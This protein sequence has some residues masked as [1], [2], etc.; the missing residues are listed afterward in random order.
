MPEQIV[1]VEDDRELREL[2]IEVLGDAGYAPAGFA[3]AGAALQALE[4]GAPGDLV[5]TDLMM[6]GMPGQELL[7]E[8]RRRAPEVN[9][10]VMTAFGSIDSAIDLVKAGAFDY[11]TK[12]LATD[13]LLLAVERA[14]TESRSR[15]E[16]AQRARASELTIPRG[17]VGES[18]PMKALY[19]LIGRA[20]RSAHP[21]LITGESGTGKELVARSL[22]AASGRGAFVTVNCGA[23]PENLLESELFGHERGAFTGADR[24]KDGLFQVADGGTLFLDEIAELPLPL[25]PKLLRALEQSEI[26]RVGSVAAQTVDVRLLAA[27]NRTLE[28]EVEVGRF[29]DDLFWRLNVLQVHVP[30][31]RERADDIPLLAHHFL[32]R[33]AD[34]GKLPRP[35]LPTDGQD[36]RSAPTTIAPDTMLALT[37][38]P[39]PG[40]VRELRNAI[41]RAGTLALGDRIEL[42]DLPARIHEGGEVAR[43]INSASRRNITLRELERLYILEIV[44]RTEGNKSKAAEL[45]GLDRKTLYRKLDEYRGDDPS[46]AL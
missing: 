39:W 37:S 23:L 1:I 14:L 12:P 45:L 21:V 32:T 20:A 8:V 19:H 26:R 17:F 24:Q 18:A 28:Q 4:R 42:E 3:S 41:Y 15:R 5:L 36:P 16:D 33:A 40:N 34:E 35:P 38:Y 29:R 13:D 43:Q 7:A 10:V 9:V 46:L 44:R 30:P 31:L 27:T 22:H 25:Q 2:L 6:P 11:L